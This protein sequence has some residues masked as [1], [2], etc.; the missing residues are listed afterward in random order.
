MKQNE[1]I[2]AKPAGF[3]SQIMKAPLVVKVFLVLL[4]IAV[5]WF[6]YSKTIGNKST[7]PQYQTDTAAKGT[8]VTSVSASGNI[9]SANSAQV[10]TQTSG[11]VT[12]IYVQ[13]GQQVKSGDP[14]ADVDLDMDGK[15]RSAQALASY[16]SAKNNLDNANATMFALQSTLFTQWNTYMNIAQN[17]TYTNPDGSPNTNNRTLPQYISTND[18]WLSAEAK[19]KDQQGAIT[20]AQTSVNSAWAS[21]LESS[22][23]IYAP[24]SGTL[25]GLS[26]Q[27][28]S[29]LTAQTNSSGTSTSQRIA[30]I[31]TVATPVAI[32]N[33]NETDAPKV[34]VNNKATLT[35][36]AFPGKTF[37]GVIVSIDTSG[38]VSSGVTTYPAYIKLDSAPE[39]IYSN[40][41]IDA[42]IITN[43]KDNVLL[44]PS[45]AVVTTNGQSNV[46]E[47]KNGTMTQVPVTIGDSNDTQTEITS[48]TV[49]DGDTVVTA[50][51]GG[52][53]ST[54]TSGTSVFSALGGRGFGGGGGGGG[55]T[56]VRRVGGN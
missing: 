44:V 26:L 53:T 34:A 29:V 12:K 39:G 35:M 49:S 41:A 10:T 23:T 45:A 6:A 9:S 4:V 32:V 1:L 14:I 15:Q 8:L 13:N 50:V 17:S 54:T 27:V 28:G 18:D 43:V 33:I 25:N 22:P 7:A 20:S 19:F 30:N 2:P 48:G 52:T 56:A 40:M 37:T 55:G 11:V 16:Q 3:F 5:A 42:K 46:R 38:V 36:D 47:L 21:Y 31:K 24:I 51:I